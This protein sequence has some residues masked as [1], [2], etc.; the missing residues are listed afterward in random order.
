VSIRSEVVICRSP[1]RRAG[2][3]A[4]SQAAESGV[5]ER[6]EADAWIGDLVEASVRRDFVF[7]VLLFTAVG[8]K[9][10]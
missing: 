1:R 3:G 9:P 7:A 8:V 2:R 10:S 6:R 5:G 4:A